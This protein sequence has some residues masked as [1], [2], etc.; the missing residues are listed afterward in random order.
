MTSPA[1]VN[2]DNVSLLS[3]NTTLKEQ[4]KQLLSEKAAWAIQKNQLAKKITSLEAAISTKKFEEQQSRKK[5]NDLST[6]Y[7]ELAQLKRKPDEKEKLYS[8]QILSLTG[9]NKKLRNQLTNS[10]NEIANKYKP[11][12]KNAQ[13]KLEKSKVHLIAISNKNKEFLQQIN[14]KER[15]IVAHER[16]IESLTE[17]LSDLEEDKSSLKSAVVELKSNSAE[18]RMPM[19]DTTN[20]SQLK[21]LHDKFDR[22]EKEFCRDKDQATTASYKRLLKK[23]AVK[24][25][26][27]WDYII[28]KLMYNYSL[29]D[30]QKNQALSELKESNDSNAKVTNLLALIKVEQQ[31]KEKIWE[32]FMG[33]MENIDKLNEELFDSQKEVAE[34]KNKTMFLRESVRVFGKRK[35]E[36]DFEDDENAPPMKK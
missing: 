21:Q 8:N 22:L 12:L 19:Q 1:A 28:K 7:K 35:R 10:N 36:D 32:L 9:E 29:V 3:E 24:R 23:V 17:R 2:V 20:K 18:P 4:V 13:D 27:D 5:Y 16:T 34:L 25:S 31:E 15:T 30:M 14:E 6:S 11:S 33:R 26:H